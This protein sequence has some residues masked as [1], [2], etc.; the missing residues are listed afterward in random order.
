[1]VF[2]SSL[3]HCQ[4]KKKGK[5]EEKEKKKEKAGLILA[6]YAFSLTGSQNIMC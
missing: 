3:E 1:M 2:F 4:T 5:T 6:V